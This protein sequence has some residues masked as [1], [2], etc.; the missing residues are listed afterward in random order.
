MTENP[1]SI[2]T[3]KEYNIKLKIVYVINNSLDKILFDCNI[4]IA[5]VIYILLRGNKG[6]KM[7]FGEKVRQARV[8][9]NITQA[10][11]A[12]RVNVNIKIWLQIC[13]TLR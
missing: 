11:L 9:K 1:F 3:R 2:L 6:G 8:E 13:M 4:Y 12:E 10:E 7:L 5:L